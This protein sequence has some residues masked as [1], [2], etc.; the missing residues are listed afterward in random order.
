[1]NS[2]NG[3]TRSAL[4]LL[5]TKNKTLHS[6]YESCLKLAQK[7]GQTEMLTRNA[8]DGKHIRTLLLGAT[9]CIQASLSL[10]RQTQW[11][12]KVA[13]RQLVT[14]ASIKSG[15]NKVSSL[16]IDCCTSKLNCWHLMSTKF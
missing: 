3:Q 1:M 6:G 4:L 8:F 12:C 7:Q 11:G 2:I 10:L 5:Y 15:F 16:I 14:L 9:Q 13:I